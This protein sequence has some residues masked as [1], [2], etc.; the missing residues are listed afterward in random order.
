MFPKIPLIHDVMIRLSKI[1]VYLQELYTI[2][3]FCLLVLFA[4]TACRSA[5]G[6]RKYR[7]SMGESKLR[8]ILL[9]SLIGKFLIPF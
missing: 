4:I 2:L 9:S 3:Q 8:E 1:K 6:K 5:K 7:C